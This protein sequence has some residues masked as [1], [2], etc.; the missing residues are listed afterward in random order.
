MNKKYVAPH[1]LGKDRMIPL[2]CEKCR[3]SLHL[4]TVS[5]SGE[6]ITLS[7]HRDVH[8][9]SSRADPVSLHE[10]SPSRCGDDDVCVANLRSREYKNQ[11][12]MAD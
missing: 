7:V 4:R 8:D 6:L 11:K 12:V 10:T 1:V 3:L 2:L 9:D 5:Q